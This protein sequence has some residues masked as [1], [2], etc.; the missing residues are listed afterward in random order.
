MSVSV[1]ITAGGSGLRLGGS[2]P[3]QF[4]FL[5]GKPILAHTLNAFNQSDTVSE[6]VVAVP[7][8][9]MPH[10]REIVEVYDIHKVRAVVAGGE[11]RATSIYAA[12]K[13]LPYIY[14]Q[15]AGLPLVSAT[16]RKIVL[17]HDGVRPFVPEK[18]IASVAESAT[19]Y[20]AAI[21]GIPLTD[22]IKEVSEN[23]NVLSTPNRNSFWRVQ[24]PQGFTYELIAKAYAQGEKDNILHTATDDSFLVERMGVPVTLVEGDPS[25]IKITTPEDMAFGEMLLMAREGKNRQ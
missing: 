2:V 11:N 22:T 5:G 21:A 3:K 25:N 4:Q 12:L 24:T 20:G 23:G 7:A 17:I 9:Y 8:A 14:S 16:H 10:T 6:I 19:N 18:L 13:E 1:I 15:G